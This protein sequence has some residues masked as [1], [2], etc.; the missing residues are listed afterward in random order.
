MGSG[1]NLLEETVS[2]PGY[3]SHTEDTSTGLGYMKARHYD[4]VIGRFFSNDPVGS[5]ASC[6]MMSNRYAY[7][8]NNPYV[9][10][11]PDGREPVAGDGYDF[12]YSPS[13]SP[14]H[15]SI[16]VMGL[17]PMTGG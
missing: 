12:G 4:P 11:D 17:Q 15:Q 7:A 1:D 3:T 16:N 5:V 14:R 6:L 13:P 8:N 2:R 9:Y 10:V